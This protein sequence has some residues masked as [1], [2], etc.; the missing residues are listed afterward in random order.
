MA[1]NLNRPTLSF[2]GGVGTVTG[3]KYLLETSGARVLL[4][5]GLFQGQKHLRLRNWDAPPFDV[6]ALDAVVLS[7]AHLDHTGYLPVLVRRGFRGAVHC[8][9]GTL[10]LLGVLLRDA[11][12]LQEE[13]ASY[14]NRKGYSKH[15]PALPL[16]DRADAEA[17]L[18]L[19]VPHSYGVR[20]TVAPGMAVTFRRAGHILGSAIVEIEFDGASP[21]RLVFTGDLGRPDQPILRDPE[22]PPAADVLLLE[23][24]YGDR[25]HA[26]DPAAE[27]A[28]VAREAAIRGGAL[29]VPAFAVGRTQ[30]LIWLLRQLEREGRIPELPVFIDSPMANRVSAIYCSHEEDLDGE[31]RAA[32]AAKECPLCCRTYGL[33]I[34]A[35][36]SRNLNDRRGPFIVIAGSGMATGGRILHHLAHRL[37]D[38]TTTVLLVGYQA[39]GTRG[40]LLRDGVPQVKM[41][42][43]FVPVRAKIEC[44]DGLSAHAGRDEMLAWVKRL[45]VPPR[46][47]FVVHG[48]PPAAES[49]GAALRQELGWNARV[50]QD[51]EIV[52]LET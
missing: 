5:C 45:S 18:K 25:T 19:L 22:P 23:S 28:R 27:L 11:A 38:P 37:D 44:L 24:T 33:V 8:T 3:S 16:F 21:S 14:A 31:M 36:E 42:G 13:E 15:R 52:E 30:T 49:L 39:I 7:H 6:S 51:G 34:T 10:E 2:F 50:A 32:M 43:R 47:A 1:H 20:F 35:E 9:S 26:Q 40:R 12:G 41:L 17:A 29:L 46:T 4:E 48:E